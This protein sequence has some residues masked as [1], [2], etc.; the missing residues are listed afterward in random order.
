[1]FHAL[2]LEAKLSNCRLPEAVGNGGLPATQT[3]MVTSPAT[4]V[5]TLPVAPTRAN[6]TFNGWNTAADGTGTAFA[7]TT[8]VSADITV[9]ARWIQEVVNGSPSQTPAP[10]SGDSNSGSGGNGYNRGR[11]RQASI[12]APVPTPNPG[13]IPRVW[14]DESN[15]DS[16]N[17]R[18]AE[19]A[20][21]AFFTVDTSLAARADMPDL[22]TVYADLSGFDIGGLNHYRIAAIHDG[23]VIGGIFDPQTEL[24]TVDVHEVGTFTIAYV[25]NLRRLKIQV[26]SN[27]IIDLADNATTQTMDVRPIIRSDRILLPIRFVAY[28]LEADVVWN[29]GTGEV[30]LVFDD[31]SLTFAIG[32][33]T[34][35]MDVPA[36]VVD[37][38]TFVPLRFVSEFFGAVVTWNEETRSVEI[39]KVVDNLQPITTQTAVP[40]P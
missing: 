35:G 28:A 11:H 8:S 32:Q 30:T 21:D 16:I 18:Y 13:T 6:H 17:L 37:D 12:P 19:S 14:V 7:A 36:Q 34:Q 23:R 9:Y 27:R 2:Q 26:G 33:T 25:R 5:G 15:R 31:R 4:N 38:R 20:T 40:N 1:M 24:F 29:G 39:L 3:A 22:F 10:D